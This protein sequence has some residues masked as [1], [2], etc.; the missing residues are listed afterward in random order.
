MI[1][2][3]DL[4]KTV[5]RSIRFSPALMHMVKKEC[6]YLGI[7]FS[8]YIRNTA[9]VAMKHNKISASV[10]ASNGQTGNEPERT[11]PADLFDLQR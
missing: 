2:N 9:T 11:W 7:D 1:L 5:I 10:E 3:N 6:A 8:T 4:K